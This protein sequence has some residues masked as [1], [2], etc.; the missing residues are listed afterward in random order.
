MDVFSVAIF[1]IAVLIIAS[2]GLMGY[3]AYISLKN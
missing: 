2:F 1:F 3:V